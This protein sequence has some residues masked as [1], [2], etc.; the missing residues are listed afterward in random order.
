M[1][2]WEKAAL[3]VVG[4]LSACSVN[5]AVSEEV[6]AV[7]VQGSEESRAEL[8]RVVSEGMYHKPVLLADN[9][10]TE[11]SIL[12]VTPRP[13]LDIEQRPLRGRDLTVPVK[14]R[15][16]RIEGKCWLERIDNKKR[17]HLVLAKCVPE[18][19]E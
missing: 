18:K 7:L 13:P 4:L 5:P 14:F 11:S 15:L 12:V 2:P 9:A 19:T 3:M 1:K 10:L 17:W 16:W 6:H 8:Q